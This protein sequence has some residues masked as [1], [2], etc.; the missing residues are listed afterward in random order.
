MITEKQFKQLFSISDNCVIPKNTLKIYNNQIKGACLLYIEVC[1]IGNKKFKNVDGTLLKAHFEFFNYGFQKFVYTLG[2][3]SK[4]HI[5]Y[6][7]KHRGTTPFWTY[8]KYSGDEKNNIKNSAYKIFEYS[9]LLKLKYKYLKYGFDIEYRNYATTDD[10]AYRCHPNQSIWWD[11]IKFNS[12]FYI[13]ENKN[14]KELSHYRIEQT[15]S[16][17]RDIWNG[18]I[19]QPIQNII[20]EIKTKSKHEQDF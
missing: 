10:E 9:I 6:V 13:D 11:G 1:N 18:K 8:T 3:K 12:L 16:N 19:S 7:D 14:Y 5:S 15:I 2:S 4:F 20:N 17:R